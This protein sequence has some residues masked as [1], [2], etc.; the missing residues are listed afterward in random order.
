MEN[1]FEIQVCFN[2]LLFS[3]S[4]KKVI[5]LETKTVTSKK[6]NKRKV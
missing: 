1:M 5:N 3:F 2:L 6:E 4:F